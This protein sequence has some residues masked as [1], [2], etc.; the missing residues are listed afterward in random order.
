MTESRDICP[1]CRRVHAGNVPPCNDLASPFDLPRFAPI[2]DTSLDEATTR[3]SAAD[4]D[5]VFDDGRTEV[6]TARHPSTNDEVTR[7]A[8]A[9]DENA[10]GVSSSAPRPRVPTPTRLDAGSAQAAPAPRVRG[11]VI[12]SDP[13]RA[14][15][16]ETIDGRYRVEGVLAEGGMGV[17]YEA[18]Q[19][20]RAPYHE[21]RCSRSTARRCR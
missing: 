13:V 6:Q 1:V 2:V 9:R 21:A 7:P 8:F 3:S 11:S 4:L 10:D 12:P 18:V 14:L 16:G 17:V 20:S 5:D 19:R 15:V